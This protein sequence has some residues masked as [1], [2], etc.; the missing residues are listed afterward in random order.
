LIPLVDSLRAHEP[1]WNE[2]G[3]LYRRIWVL[4]SRS[5][6]SEARQLEDAELSSVVARIRG[7]EE[8]GAHTDARIAAIRDEEKERVAAAVA[9][10]EVLAPL[11]AERLAAYAPASA[12]AAKPAARPLS[13]KPAGEARGI[14]DFIE[15]MLVQDRAGSP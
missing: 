7:S 1:P 11:L 6:H 10:A 15:E 4:R 9:F 3:A 12:A 13:L 8:G 14:A 2:V 5:R